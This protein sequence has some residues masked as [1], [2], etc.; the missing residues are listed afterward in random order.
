MEDVLP[1]PTPPRRYRRK[2]QAC[3]DCGSQRIASIL[4]GLPGMTPELECAMRE[5]RVVLGGCAVSDED[6]AWT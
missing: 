1:R 2:P 4:Y 6:P 5:G 3:P